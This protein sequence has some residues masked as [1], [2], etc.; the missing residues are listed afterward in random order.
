M[1]AV[2]TQEQKRQVREAV[3][4]ARD[5]LSAD[6][7]RAAS[8][9][10]RE[11]VLALPELADARNVFVFVSFGSEVDTHGLIDSL[12]GRGQQVAIPRIID[13]TTIRA[14]PMTGWDDLVAGKWGILAPVHDTPAAGP[15][16]VAIIPGVAFT[17]A[18]ER[19]GHG[20]GYY[21]RWLES[22]PVGTS[23]ALAFEEHLVPEL[24][25]EPHDRPVDM[26]VTP[27]RVI[28]G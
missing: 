12:L 14:V 15:F 9:R 17:E 20:R 23:I 18:R 13:A 16:D 4:A 2:P 24:P 22:N 28:S 21:D 25:V 8:A 11:R 1:S 19:I 5:G 27:E 26:V 7:R 10:I 3:L 6:T